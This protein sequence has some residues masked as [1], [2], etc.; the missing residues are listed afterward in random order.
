MFCD[1]VKARGR[2]SY[3]GQALKGEVGKSVGGVFLPNFFA[4]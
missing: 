3:I 1:V 4:N 2:N